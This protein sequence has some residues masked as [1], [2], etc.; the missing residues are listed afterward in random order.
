MQIPFVKYQGTGNDFILVDDRSRLFPED[1]QLIR[2]ICDRHY[3]IGADGVILLRNHAEFD[4]EMI[5]RNPD[6]SPASFCGNGGRCIVAFAQSLEIIG[7][8][9]K[10][11][12]PDGIHNAVILGEEGHET[13]V[14]LEMCDAIIYESTETYC[15]LNTGTYH[16]VEFVDDFESLDVVGKGR[17]VRNQD[18]FLP[19]G[20]NVNFVSGSSDHLKVRTYEKGVENETLSCGT[21]VTASAIAASLQQGGTDFMV[22][23]PGGKLRVTFERD[24]DRFFHICLEGN[25]TRVFEGQISI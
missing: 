18:R 5:F 6:G 19:H 14:R 1:V 20:T 24:G 3:G 11:L 12:A 15:Y 10:F 16:Y 4:F 2:Q 17:S 21:G 23:T 8:Q 9:T 22:N 25:A 7:I 13:L